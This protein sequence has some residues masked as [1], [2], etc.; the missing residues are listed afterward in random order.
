MTQATIL[1]IED[2]PDILRTN[3]AA[4]EL[5]GHR[6]LEA[7]TLAQGTAMAQS[8]PVDLVLLDILLPDSTS[9][10]HCREV[11]GL[12][13]ASVLILSAL[14]TKSDV[15]A[16]LRAGG[17]DYLVKP[18]LMDEMLARVEAL[19]R[20]RKTQLPGEQSLALAGLKLS[21]TARVAR[22]H[23]RDLLLTPREFSI[24]AVLLKE[25]GAFVTSKKLYE[26]I[27]GSA[28]SMDTRTVRQHVRRLRKKLGNGAPITI[29]AQQ[30]AGY[31][32]VQCGGQA[33]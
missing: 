18:Y 2:N 8:Q 13:G 5:E 7:T 12:E 24:L 21:L 19:L 20:R 22:L 9:L 1:M 16:G 30:G 26:Q 17:D 4:L 32:V 14:N 3:R 33:E 15:I 25:R 29:E 10:A 27:W 28:P 6:V 11:L 23:G 31:R